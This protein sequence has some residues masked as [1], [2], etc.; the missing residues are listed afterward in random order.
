MTM[1]GPEWRSPG[2]DPQVDG[3]VES[4][5]GV[6]YVLRSNPKAYFGMTRGDA[7]YSHILPL[8]YDELDTVLLDGF[9]ES[10]TARLKPNDGAS[11]Y[12]P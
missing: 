10:I 6:K 8:S 11:G 3:Y 4:D 9:A 12:L 1:I 2:L 5:E 7:P